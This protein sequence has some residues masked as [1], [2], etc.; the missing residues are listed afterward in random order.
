[1]KRIAVSLALLLAACVSSEQTF[2]ATGAK[3]HV[4]NCTPGWTHGIVGNIANAQ[5]S[6][7]T[8]YEEAGRICGS[9]GYDIIERV[10]EGQYSSTAIAGADRNTAQAY[11][12]ATTTTN[13]TMVIKCKGE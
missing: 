7:G 9:R 4:I 2:T 11:G 5:T 13:R 1:M 12:S 6:W 3:G 10:G 8:C